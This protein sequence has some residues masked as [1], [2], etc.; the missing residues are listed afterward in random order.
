MGTE[1]TDG[2]FGMTTTDTIRLCVTR[3]AK[4]KDGRGPTAERVREVF[5]YDAETGALTW[6]VRV[7]SMV[8][9]GG[10]AGTL[11]SDGYIRV[12]LDGG[13]YAASHLIWLYVHG[14]WPEGREVD[15]INSV[16]SDNRIDNLRLVTREENMQNQ[17][18]ARSDCGAGLIGVRRSRSKSERWNAAIGKNGARVHLGSFGTKEEAHAAYL[19][20]KAQLH[21]PTAWQA[22]RVCTDTLI[23]AGGTPAIAADCA[24]AARRIGEWLKA[25]Q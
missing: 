16:R 17:W 9:I 18:R 4:A 20:A 23:R 22:E 1:G 21:I 10:P 25:R 3:C 11:K 24:A 7:N 14:E 6:K 8:Q 12:R 5:A 15:H 13:R 2:V 19:A